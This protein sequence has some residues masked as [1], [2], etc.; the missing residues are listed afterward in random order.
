MTRPWK[1]SDGYIQGWRAENSRK[2][3]EA[4]GRIRCGEP[5]NKAKL[6][7]QP[8]QLPK[9]TRRHCALGRQGV[10]RC[11]LVSCCN[12]A[13]NSL[14]LFWP[15]HGSKSRAILSV[16]IPA[17]CM[18][19]TRGD[20]VRNLPVCAIR[21]GGGHRPDRQPEQLYPSNTRPPPDGR[22]AGYGFGVL[23]STLI[24]IDRVALHARCSRGSRRISHAS[25]DVAG[26][27]H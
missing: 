26:G 8:V 6:R 9:R 22:A 4:N 1:P 2:L 10:R 21:H 27:R 5:L 7:R 18:S 3:A 14:R 17:S 16:G 23:L 25:R 19:A 15:T 12:R 20:Q 11:R 13:S 24:T